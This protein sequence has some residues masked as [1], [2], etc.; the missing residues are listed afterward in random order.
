[1]SLGSLLSEPVIVHYRETHDTWA[2]PITTKCRL[3]EGKEYEVLVEGEVRIHR[4]SGTMYL[5]PIPLLVENLKPGD[6]VEIDAR[7]RTIKNVKLQRK[8]GGAVHHI[9]L[10]ISR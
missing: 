8:G 6:K 4:Q 2:T 3:E 1:M 10:S 7:K 5:A 9:E